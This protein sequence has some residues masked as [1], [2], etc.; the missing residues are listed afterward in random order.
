MLKMKAESCRLPDP[1]DSFFLL[2]PG[3]FWGSLNYLGVHLSV[4]LT[5]MPCK[6][7][8]KAMVYI[9]VVTFRQL[10]ISDGSVLTEQ[11]LLVSIWVFARFVAWVYVM[12]A[13]F[14][15][16]FLSYLQMNQN[17][18]SQMN[19]V[20]HNL[21]KNWNIMTWNVRGINSTWKWNP[22]KNKIADAFC[23][24]VCLQETKKRK[25]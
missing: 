2:V 22:V 19:Q 18:T 1:W 7:A 11:L 9:I 24:I 12:R 8:L 21:T 20:N 13:S 23:D 14:K 16:F 5:V 4:L 3:C 10:V 6:I 25:C 15:Q 17:Q